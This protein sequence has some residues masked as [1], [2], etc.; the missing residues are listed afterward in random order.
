M[1][2]KETT[3]KGAYAITHE[4]REDERGYFTYLFL[5]EDFL[6]HG[7]DFVPVRASQLFNKEKGIIR[8]M[9]LQHAPHE[10]QKLIWCTR[11]RVFDVVVDLRPDSSSFRKWFGIELSSENHMVLAIPRGCAH[12]FQTLEDDTVL[13]YLASEE[14]S[15][16]DEWG[17]RW[18]DPLI[19]IEWPDNS[20]MVVSAKDRVWPFLT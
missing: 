14:Y 3:C 11:G 4:L 12:G 6:K 9:H 1:E 20:T 2:F 7:I 8:G 10:E 5:R 19:G 18:D 13:E 16:K 17:V 15:P